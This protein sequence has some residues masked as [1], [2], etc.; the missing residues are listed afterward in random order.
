MFSELNEIPVVV[1]GSKADTPFGKCAAKGIADG[2][3]AVACI[4]QRDIQ[5][6]PPGKG[7]AGRVLN[8]RFLGETAL[9][10]IGVEG[11]EKS[12]FARVRESLAKQSGSDVGIM[13]D[14]KDILVFAASSE[15]KPDA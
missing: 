13:V 2:A 15:D 12:L 10:E 6:V 5:L 8:T 4:R 11:L 14:P 7:R 9:M 3:Q 1:K